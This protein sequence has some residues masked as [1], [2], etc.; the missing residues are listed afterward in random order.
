MF[1]LRSQFSAEP[2]NWQATATLPCASRAMARICCLRGSCASAETAERVKSSARRRW[3][4]IGTSSAV[5]NDDADPIYRVL[6]GDWRRR[7]QC[8]VFGC[9]G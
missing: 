5:G 8:G 6:L 3:L 9:R 4:S 2:G 7:L 1:G